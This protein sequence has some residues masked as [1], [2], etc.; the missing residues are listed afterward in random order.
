MQIH[1]DYDFS[2]KPAASCLGTSAGQFCAL[3]SGDAGPVSNV[4]RRLQGS[5][6]SCPEQEKLKQL[7]RKSVS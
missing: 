4:P 5:L 7:R 1:R 3:L 6:A 2:L